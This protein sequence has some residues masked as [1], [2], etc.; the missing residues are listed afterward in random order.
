[1]KAVRDRYIRELRSYWKNYVFQ[2]LF[3]VV[4]IFI[5]LSLLNIRKSPV[6]ISSLGA[7]AFIVFAMPKSNS[8]RSVA[9]IGGYFIGVIVGG[10]FELR[11]K[12]VFPI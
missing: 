8:A 3:A 4:T 5:L 7:T 9:I 6:I 2:S 12:R 1:M 10:R 11:D